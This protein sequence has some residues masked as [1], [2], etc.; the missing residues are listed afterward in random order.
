MKP[1]NAMGIAQQ[2][3]NGGRVDDVAAA[4]GVTRKDVMD[5]GFDS[6]MRYVEGQ[7]QFVPT[8]KSR[9]IARQSSAT[10]AALP[11]PPA[12]QKGVIALGLECP[13][14][15]VRRAAERAR[16]AVERLRDLLAEWEDR[17]SARAEVERLTAEL[18]LAK[19]R[20][21][22]RTTAP[23]PAAAPPDNHEV[24]AWAAANGVPCPAR[25]RVPGAVRDAYDAAQRGSS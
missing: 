4:F 23:V 5:A 20:L 1:G 22:G 13:D 17:A 19:A 9:T 8:E 6:G 10:P 21:R 16:D 3:D 7:D 25:G 11:K 14:A 2:L 15:R 24:R 12:P 18:E